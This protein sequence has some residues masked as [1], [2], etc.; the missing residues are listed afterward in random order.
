MEPRGLEWVHLLTSALFPVVCSPRPAYGRITAVP[1]SIPRISS[2]LHF[3]PSFFSFAF[4]NFVPVA[5]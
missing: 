3:F 2:S 1:T 4:G 5:I